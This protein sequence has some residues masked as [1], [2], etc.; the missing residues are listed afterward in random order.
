M[1]HI[2]LMSSPG[3]AQEA[4]LREIKAL[5]HD[6]SLAPDVGQ[7]R[8]LMSATPHQAVLVD[9]NT[10]MKADEREKRELMQMIDRFP[11]AVVR[12]DSETNQIRTMSFGPTGAT[13][14]LNTF[15]EQECQSSPPNACGS[16][17]VCP[18]I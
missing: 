11:M 12:H 6:V 14:G 3:I 16:G 7:L 2:A 17:N 10:R 9:L 15:F 1:T 18:S 4:Y 5:G 8:Q 13:L